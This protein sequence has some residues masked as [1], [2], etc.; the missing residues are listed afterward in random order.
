MVVGHECRNLGS[1]VD[2]EDKKH[3][4]RDHE[5]TTMC[6]CPFCK[7]W[8]IWS[9]ISSLKEGK[10][11]NYEDEKECKYRWFW[12][13]KYRWFDDLWESFFKHIE[14]REE[15]DKET[16]P[17]NTWIFDEESSNPVGSH[18]HEYDGY[19]Q[20][21]DEI[22]NISM[23]GTSNS[24]YIIQWHDNISNNNHLERFEKIVRVSSMLFVMF[25]CSYFTIEF[26]YYIEKE[27]RTKEFE[28]RDFEEE[29]D[30]KW[31]R[32]TKDGSTNHSPENSFAAKLRGEFFG[33]HSD[34]NRIVS[35]HHNIDKDDI[36]EGKESST[37][38]ECQE[39]SGQCI[40]HRIKLDV[41]Y[42]IDFLEIAIFWPEGMN[43]VKL[44]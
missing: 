33:G 31:E 28:P 44:I 15:D 25:S 9:Q 2:R 41:I 38:W 3:K 32:D 35:T 18:D 40:K 17:L 24:E 12:D 42:Y 1:K 39:V 11:T 8:P 14:C 34:K 21:D 19:D 37:G 4:Y 6:L 43:M 26:P 30:S 5:S 22:H 36:E 16:H 13:T 27:Y 20:T 23:T 29:Y 7:G 10:S